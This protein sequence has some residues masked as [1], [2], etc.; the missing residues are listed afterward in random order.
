MLQEKNR[1]GRRAFT[2]VEIMIVIAIIGLIAAIAIPNFVKARQESQATMCTAW[3]ERIG[4]A[5]VQVAFA[6]NLREDE[7][8]TD[9]QLIE[10]IDDLGGAITQVDGSTDLCPAAGTYSVNDISTDPT[11]SLAGELGEHRLK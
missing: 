4:G 5:K 3:L 1:P 8:P 7:T 11:C 2:L 10:Y 6:E 9:E